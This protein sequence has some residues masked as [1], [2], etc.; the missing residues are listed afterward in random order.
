MQYLK[1]IDLENNV[2][3]YD[4]YNLRDIMFGDSQI[5][6]VF[7]YCAENKDFVKTLDE[8]MLLVRILNVKGQVV[9]FPR[10]IMLKAFQIKLSEFDNK[11]IRAVVFS[12][13][14]TVQT[15]LEN[16]SIQFAKIGGNFSIVD[17]YGDGLFSNFEYVKG[18][19]FTGNELIATHTKKESPL[20]IVSED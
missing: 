12:D 4:V 18:W 20:F 14:V 17:N 2:S 7:N 16:T 6:T 1:L 19:K 8:F 10:D 15:V 9:A 11:T 13:G 5:E 3:E